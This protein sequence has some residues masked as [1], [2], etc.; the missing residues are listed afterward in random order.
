MSDA[1]E[2]ASGG[3]R[4][5]RLIKEQS[6]YLRQHA[7]NPVEWNPW[8]DEALGRA[9][10]E[11]KPILLSIGY[12]ACHWCHV[13]ERESFEN[14]AIA[15][16]M[17]ENFVPIKV[18][19]E[20]RP[21]LDQIYMDAVQ[22]MA[23]RGG[24]PLTVFL[25]PDGKPFYGGTY[26]PPEDRHGMPG[27]PRVLTAVAKAYHEKPGDIAQNVERL[28]HAL[29]ELSSQAAESGDLHSG[30]A[31]AAARA[32][33]GHYDHQHGGIGGAPKFPSAFVFSLFL[34]VYQASGA[35]EFGHMVRETLSAMAKGGIYDQIG[36][37]F[38]RYSVDDHW[39]VP[40][41]EKMLYDNA[42]LAML[43]LDAGRELNEP[44]FLNVA[45]ETLDYVVREMQ[46]PEGGLYATQ[47]AD[48]EGEEGKFFLWTPEE[49]RA[50]LG[51]ELSAIAERY[52]DISEDGNF[53]GSNIAHR[54][55][56]VEQAARLFAMSRDAMAEKVAEI[57]R[58][59]F[60]AR[61]H[62][63]KPARDEKVLAA[64]NGMMIAS[65]AEGYRVFGDA[66]YL[67]AAERAVD[68]VITRMWNGNALKRS[69][70]DGVARFNGYLEDYALMAAALV[71]VYEASLNLRYLEMAR[72]LA[73][74]MIERFADRERGGFFFTSDDH[75][76]LITR[77]KPAFDGS[78]PSGNSA[79][80]MALLRL[81]AYTGE[82]HYLAE[83]ARTLRVFRAQ[84]EQQA[85]GFSFM[86]E[87]AQLYETGATE[88]VIVGDRQS[89][90]FREWVERLGLLYIPNRAIFVVD[91]KAPEASFVPEAARGRNAVDGRLTAYVCRE[92]ACS[93]PLTSWDELQAAVKGNPAA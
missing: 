58:R 92:R 78:T 10:A 27:F 43:Y 14:E 23:G 32:L 17:N 2:P 39:L 41:F 37:G 42:L 60:A 91:P 69:F 12:S 21:D 67:A 34:R 46:S 9:R 35:L 87:A 20:E 31:E 53:E 81:H 18:D 29:D 84:M 44:E 61:E 55:I 65:L 54:T 36:G 74:A 30:T 86:L 73:D 56:D 13:M 90:E 28:T 38:H 59:M 51:E 15:G 8:D 62:R 70:K 83:A 79:A 5:N 3:R 85:F 72:E 66:R 76:A 22:L 7:Y 93:I 45:R 88:I 68:F 19:R 71:A 11:N 16:L 25:T 82:E 50:L 57:R 47:D 75:E 24:W 33:A 52:F 89:A 49:S 77:S 26:F 63:V 1:H 64:W 40:H 4:P 48:S 6:P 80:V